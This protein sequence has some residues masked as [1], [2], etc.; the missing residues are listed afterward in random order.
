MNPHR[1][2]ATAR[3]LIDPGANYSVH[4]RTDG[5][6]SQPA[7]PD[8]QELP[9]LDVLLSARRAL[10]AQP[11]SCVEST[12]PDTLDIRTGDGRLWLRFNDTS[13]GENGPDKPAL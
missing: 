7:S 5:G 10:R 8:H 2:Y 11:T 1:D 6:W 3:Q 12:S 13:R 9:G 4:V